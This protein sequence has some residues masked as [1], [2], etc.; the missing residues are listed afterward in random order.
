MARLR[1][2]GAHAARRSI[3]LMMGASA[4]FA[5]NDA[6][7]KFASQS[8]AGPQLIFLRSV[9]ASVLFLA[10]IWQQG[11]LGRLRDV[12]HPR[13][14]LRGTADAF[15]TTMYLLSLFH[16]PIANATAI[17]LAAPIFMTVC[18]VLFLRERAGAVRWLAVGLGFAGVLL[19]VQPA[20]SGF[21]AW[22]LLCVAGT[23]LHAVRDLL[24]R[25]IS[26]GTPSMVV[27]LSSTLALGLLGG[28]ALLWQGWQ[29][30][31]WW[32]LAVVALAACFL[33]SAYM[34]LI[35]S[36]RLGEISLVAP[37]RYTALLFAVGFG[38]FVW[39]QWPNGWAWAGIALLLGSG[40]YA[41][42]RERG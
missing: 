39:G 37:F 28:A 26:S 32:Q 38:Y 36:L 30:V 1:A 2:E 33:A 17:N 31:A 11:L 15:G 34:L 42:H 4:L 29:P 23:L 16:L 22:A 10:L 21:N 24:T 20:G 35:A 13:L 41:A 18:A 6:T 9:F 19:V 25:G 8:L 12:A 3:L 5:A 40:T 7:V 14:L 27:A